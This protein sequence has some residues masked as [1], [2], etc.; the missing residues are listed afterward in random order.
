MGLPVLIMGESGSGK[1]YSLKNLEPAEVSIFSVEK[2]RLPF[3]KKLPIK[4]HAKY[5]DILARSP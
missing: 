1:T 3:Q 4:P 2:A 5:Q